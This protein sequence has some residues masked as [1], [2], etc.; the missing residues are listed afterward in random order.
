MPCSGHGGRR[1]DS[2]RAVACAVVCWISCLGCSDPDLSL[3]ECSPRGYSQRRLPIST[4]FSNCE[5]GI[6]RTRATF[7]LVRTSD[8]LQGGSVALVVP[9]GAC[10]ISFD[11]SRPVDDWPIW[12]WLVEGAQLDISLWDT[13]ADTRGGDPLWL[14]LR[15][16]VTGEPLFTIYQLNGF[17]IA[18]G[19]FRDEVGIDAEIVGPVCRDSSGAE[20][21]LLVHGYDL[22][23]SA[24][25]KS[26]RLGVGSEG[27]LPSSNASLSW[28]I[29]TGVMK[30]NLL[31][32]N[33]PLSDVRVG[34]F[35]Q[36][37]A[38]TEPR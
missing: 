19:T 33:S 26:I 17:L 29:Q 37:V 21:G 20:S 2:F 16:S 1:T 12:P 34:E 30:N 9:E 36:V 28:R 35:F 6:Y 13:G 8:D 11:V 38:W 7:D 4:A 24:E 15:D 10:A 18:D 31:D 25:G 22:K 27:S 3:R 23:L 14:V 5:E 32:P